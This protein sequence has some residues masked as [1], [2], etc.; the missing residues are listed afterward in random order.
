MKRITVDLADTTLQRLIVV[1]ERERRHPRDQAALYVE[2]A[3][4]RANRGP[5]AGDIDSVALI[6]RVSNGA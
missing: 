5:E 4:K 1:A 6:S 2:R 3:I